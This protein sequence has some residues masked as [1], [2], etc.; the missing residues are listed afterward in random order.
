MISCQSWPEIM[1]PSRQRRNLGLLEGWPKRL[2]LMN[3]PHRA[4]AVL[5]EFKTDLDDFKH[6]EALAE[7]K[8]KKCQDVL[9]R[10]QFHKTSVQQQI[11]AIELEENS[12]SGC[13]VK[14]TD[15]APTTNASD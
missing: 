11:S 12:S 1:V 3:V 9:D 7:T 5:K 6:I 8:T 10:H 14:A 13:H 4:N 15:D 2:Q